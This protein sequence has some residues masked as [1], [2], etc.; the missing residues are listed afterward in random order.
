[1]KFALISD[2]IDTQI[3][4]RLAGIEGVV[5]TTR[6]EMLKTLDEMIQDESIGVILM[7]TKVVQLCPDKIADLKLKLHKPLLTEIPDCHGSG[8]IGRTIDSY[9][10]EAIGI[11][12]GG[13]D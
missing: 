9:V 11:K 13:Q 7:T 12:I 10:S 4:L 1:M 8:E 5:V 6:E 3:G 2:N